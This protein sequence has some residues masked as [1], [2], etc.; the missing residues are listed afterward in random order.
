MISTDAVNS[1]LINKELRTIAHSHTYSYVD[2]D[3][4]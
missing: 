3:E 1:M 2:I 4:I